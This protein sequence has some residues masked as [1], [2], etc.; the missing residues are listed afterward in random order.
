[1]KLYELRRRSYFVIV[2]DED[3]ETFFFEHTDGMYSV[4]FD[5]NGDMIHLSVMTEVEDV[6]TPEDGYDDESDAISLSQF[7]D[8]VGIEHG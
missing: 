7:I 8:I 1:M 4:C 2:G 3:R 6:T 5:P